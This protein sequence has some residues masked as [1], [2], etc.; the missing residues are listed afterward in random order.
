MTLSSPP[1][2]VHISDGGAVSQGSVRHG[3]RDAQRREGIAIRRADALENGA[4]ALHVAGARPA[5]DPVEEVPSRRA[6]R[7]D[8]C[9][10]HAD[11]GPRRPRNGHFG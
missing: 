2:E 3:L 4:P 7:R 1:S 5:C 9:L 8:D 11:D 10:C 6:G